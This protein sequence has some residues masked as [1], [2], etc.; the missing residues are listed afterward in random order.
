MREQKVT[1][2]VAVAGSTAA[3]SPTPALLASAPLVAV[4]PAR[5]VGGIAH[6]V[7]RRAVHDVQLRWLRPLWWMAETRKVARVPVQ[8]LS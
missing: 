4:E 6:S 3:A 7:K 5:A 8:V 2:V 1:M